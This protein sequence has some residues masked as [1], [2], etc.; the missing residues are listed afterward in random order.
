[1]T[2]KCADVTGEIS[3][4]VPLKCVR[5]TVVLYRH[6]WPVLEKKK[7]IHKKTA[8]RM[9]GKETFVENACLCGF[10]KT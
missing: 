1:M 9:T 10:F 6:V 4:S 3:H 5:E 7:K 2:V 8:L